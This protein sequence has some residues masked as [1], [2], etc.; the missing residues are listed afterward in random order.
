MQP[1]TVAEYN[2]PTSTLNNQTDVLNFAAGL[3]Q[4]AVNAYDGAIPLF[5]DQDP[6]RCRRFHPGIGIHA[7]AILNY[8]LGDQPPTVAFVS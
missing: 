4:G 3:E 7:L 5:A 2:F 1:K 8:A 6:G